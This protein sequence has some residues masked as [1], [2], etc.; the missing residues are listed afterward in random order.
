MKTSAIKIV[1]TYLNKKNINNL[2]KFA[3]TRNLTIGAVVIVIIITLSYLIRP[4]FFDYK[5]NE[6]VL[7]KKINNYLK[8]KSNIRGDV[9]Y[10]FF[11]KPKIVI[12]DL[13]LNFIDSKKKAIILN[14]S[15]FLISISNLES[16]KDIKIKKIYIKK[17]R[18]EIFS[19]QF[20]EYLEYFQK[21]KVDNLVLKNCEIFFIDDQGNNITLTGFN[22]K[23][24]YGKD[25]EKIS[26]TGIFSGNKFKINFLNKQNDEKFLDFSIP[27][28]DSHLKI[29]FSKYSNLEKTSGKL[30]LKIFNNV[31]LLNFDGDSVYK[32]S[33]SFFRNKFLSSKLDGTINFR[34]NFYFDLN[35]E[36]NQ[37]NLRKLFRYY[38]TFMKDE[39]TGQFNISKKINGKVIVSLKNADSYIGRLGNTNFILLFENGDLKIKNGLTDINKNAKLKFNVSLVGKGKNQKIAFFINFSSNEGKVFFNKLNVNSERKDIGISATGKI[40]VIGKKIKFD[41]LFINEEKITGRNLNIV[42]DSFDQYVIKDGVLGFLDFFKIKKFA[43]EVF[44]NLE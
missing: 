13:E 12:K 7:K 4:I 11:P 36:I 21:Y 24:T 43:K 27:G 14:E 28:L 30:N 22:L 20:R 6:E 19:N 31:L 25:S 42:E 17:Q 29:I 37:V 5:L 35:S 15:N 34:D 10:H 41:N 9:S 1:Q 44:D 39:T 18:I 32:I 40:N 3:N 26:T 16:I 38:D 8:V 23:N 2:K 33:E